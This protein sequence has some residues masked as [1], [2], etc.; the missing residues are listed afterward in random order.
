MIAKIVALARLV[1]GGE[2][3][4]FDVRGPLRLA[5]YASVGVAVGLVVV[6]LEVVAIDVVLEAVLD[7]P[8]WVQAAAPGAGM[9]VAVAVLASTRNT[10]ATSDD[11]ITAFHTGSVISLRPVGARLVA[12]VA[13]IGA[14]GAAGLEGPSIYAGSVVGQRIARRFRWLLGPDATRILLV[15]GAAAGVAAVFKAPATG[16][17]FAL[18]APYQRDTSAS[19]LIPSL[20]ASAVSYL[21]FV[22]VLGTDRFLLVD[23]VEV[24]LRDEIL[25]ALLVG[26]LAGL[27]A[28]VLATLFHWAKERHAVRAPYRVISAA[29]ILAGVVGAYDLL[30]VPAVL[31]PGAEQALDIALDPATSVG[32]VAAVF[33]L[34]A[35]ATATVFGAGGVGGV[36]IPL[37]VQGVLLGRLVQDLVGAEPTGLYPV[38][39]LAAVLGAG[40]RVPLAAVMFVAE[41]TGQAGYVIPALLATAVAQALMGRVSVASGQVGRREGLL[42]QRLRL[43]V[44]A[45]TITDLQPVGLDERLSDVI[46]RYADHAP[47]PAIPVIDDTGYRGLLV[48]RDIATAMFAHGFDATVADAVIEIDALHHAQPAVDAAE[49][50]ADEDTAVLPVCDDSGRPIGVVTALSLSGLSSLRDSR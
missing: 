32:V 18:E 28:R 44:S 19:A 27:A 16:V 5:T 30:D 26:V 41:T 36:F 47:A 46:D 50:M 34:R 4:E 3:G 20:I 38:I 12:A 42:E 33:V 40:Y 17:L 24:P 7:A 15:A 2:E 31:G 8:L 37:V 22:A 48:L 13:T 10:P 23:P 14:G 35:L 43:P 45:V 11:Y 9:G 1:L 6:G 49:R 21:T 29:V 25:G 39:G